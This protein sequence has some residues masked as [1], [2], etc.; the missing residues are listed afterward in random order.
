MDNRPR[1]RAKGSISMTKLH[2]TRPH[3]L[4]IL[5]SALCAAFSVACGAASTPTQTP[6]P[7]T[8]TPEPRPS[9][10]VLAQ[11]KAAF[12]R[13]GCVACHKIT[14]LSDQAVAAPPLDDA[15]KLM[16]ETINLPEYKKSAGKAKT[17]RER[18][19]EAI[20]DPSAFVYPKCP[21][22]PCVP[23]TMP[24]NYKDIIRPEELD[25]LVTFLLWQGR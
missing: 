18:I 10:E 4:A 2:H 7:P 13:I 22:G 21:Q 11:G 3:Y 25:L 5:A 16:V 12:I 8:P 6:L 15:Y 23:G 19:I 20:L 9:A 24:S 1:Q 17:P 14:G